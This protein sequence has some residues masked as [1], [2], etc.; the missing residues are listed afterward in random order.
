MRKTSLSIAFIFTFFLAALLVGCGSEN[1]KKQVT[2]DTSTELAFLDSLQKMEEPLSPEERELFRNYVGVLLNRTGQ[3]LSKDE[4]KDLKQLNILYARDKAWG[5]SER[6]ITINGLTYKEI[7]ESGETKNKKWT[8]EVVVRNAM[9]SIAA[10]DTDPLNHPSK[11]PYTPPQSIA[12]LEQYGFSLP[13]GYSMT[14]SREE[15]QQSKGDYYYKV[16]VITSDGKLKGYNNEQD[17]I[18]IENIP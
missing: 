6:L 7:I 9:L 14:F 11:T 15:Y 1:S 13:E 5:A 2:L 8:I 4:R 16:T 18:I 10:Y 17:R 3:G 12:D